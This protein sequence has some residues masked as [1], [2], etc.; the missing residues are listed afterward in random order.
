MKTYGQIAHDMGAEIGGWQRKWD[1]RQ[2]VE[3]EAIA[4]AVIMEFEE[5]EEKK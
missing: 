5:R 3:W 2:K 4:E 1:D